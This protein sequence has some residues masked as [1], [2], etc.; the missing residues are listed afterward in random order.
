[1]SRTRYGA[2][3]KVAERLN[4]QWKMTIRPEPFVLDDEDVAMLLG[5]RIGVIEYNPYDDERYTFAEG[6]GRIFKWERRHS[7]L[8]QAKALRL[9][10]DTYDLSQ[11][12]IGSEG[13]EYFDGDNELHQAML[14]KVRQIWPAF[15]NKRGIDESQTE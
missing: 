12:Q 1:M 8:T 14:M 3:G 11:Y 5:K 13:Y 10:S 4:G 7:A 15:C 6:M 2:H 9:I